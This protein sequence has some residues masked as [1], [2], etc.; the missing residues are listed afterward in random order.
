MREIERSVPQAVSCDLHLGPTISF[1]VLRGEYRPSDQGV[2]YSHPANEH[3]VRDSHLEKAKRQSRSMAEINDRLPY[4]CRE[5]GC[6]AHGHPTGLLGCDPTKRASREESNRP[7]WLVRTMM[8]RLDCGGR[9]APETYGA[10]LFCIWNLRKG[11]KSGEPSRLTRT[12]G[13]PSYS[14]MSP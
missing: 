2:D 12:R 1:F 6:M 7:G 9:R 14:T 11:D 10:G 5:E 13:I 4:P 3:L 8:I